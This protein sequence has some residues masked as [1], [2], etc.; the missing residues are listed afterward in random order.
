MPIIKRILNKYLSSQIESQVHQKLHERMPTLSTKVKPLN[1]DQALTALL[2]GSPGLME[3]IFNKIALDDQVEAVRDSRIG[4][5]TGLELD[6]YSA[7][8]DDSAAEDQIQFLNDQMEQIDVTMLLEKIFE[9]KERF[10][11]VIEPHWK[12]SDMLEIDGFTA[13]DNDLFLFDKADV[14]ISAGGKKQAFA[15][16][17]SDWY[18]AMKIRSNKSLLLRCLRPYI[19]RRFGY[20]AWAHFLEVFS[21]PFR[22]ARYPDGAG[23]EIRDA[24]WDAVRAIGQDGAAALPKSADIEFIE[25]N[26]KGEDN[27]NKLIEKTDAAISKA[28][29]GHSAAVDATP[30]KLGQ[31]NSAMEARKDLVEADQKF[32]LKWLYKGIVRPLLIFNFATP[33]PIVPVFKQDEA[34]D[35]EQLLQWL[36]M[37]YEMGGEVDP[38]QFAEHGVVIQPNAELLRKPA[39]EFTF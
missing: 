2:G 23:K 1:A 25:A 5:T 26:R 21:D 11:K 13:H 30:G 38:N 35:R 31:E 4:A 24:V 27:F 39:N 8:E 3:P 29:L 32:I 15:D 37:Y 28:Y 36:K 7:E 17:Q 22:V 16:S 33:A 18:T 12:L 10:F 9:A 6:F 14:Y 34:I 20:D 19:I